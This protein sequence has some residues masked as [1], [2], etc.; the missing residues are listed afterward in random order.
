MMNNSKKYFIFFLITILVSCRADRPNFD[1]NVSAIDYKKIIKLSNE[2]TNNSFY[3]L[4]KKIDTYLLNIKNDSIGISSEHN[5]VYVDNKIVEISKNNSLIVINDS[6]YNQIKKISTKGSG[7]EELPFIR[8]FVVTSEKIIL[9]NNSLRKFVFIDYKNNV[10]S[11]VNA[12]SPSIPYDINDMVLLSNGLCL[13]VGIDD[14]NWIKLLNGLPYQNLYLL[15]LEKQELLGK[16]SI[17]PLNLINSIKNKDFI[18]SPVSNPFLIK[19]FQDTLYIGNRYSN[20]I[21]ISRLINSNIETIKRLVL[22]KQIFRLH[23]PA[24]KEKMNIPDLQ[25]MKYWLYTGHN[26]IN[27]FVTR[28]YIIAYISRFLEN[29]PPTYSILFLGKKSLRINKII[30]YKGDYYFRFATNNYLY[31]IKNEKLGSEIRLYKIPIANLF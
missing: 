16:Y 26:L 7:P 21:I 20:E 1:T 30:E 8:S 4:N 18:S 11:Q 29:S 5:M 14:E 13:A 19:D 2:I 23:D 27:F 6:N 25:R 24:E 9:F 12:K 28:D 22:P 17:L 3:D 15:D 10:L 31:F